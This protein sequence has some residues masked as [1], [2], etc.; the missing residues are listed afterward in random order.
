VADYLDLVAP[1][2]EQ[3]KESAKELGVDWRILAAQVIVESGGNPM[4][5]GQ[6]GEIGLC[7]FFLTTARDFLTDVTREQ[8]FEPLTNLAAQRAYLAWLKKYLHD[9]CET[10]D[11]RLALAAYNWG[12]GR[13]RLH[14]SQGR[15]FEDIPGHVRDG[16]VGKIL[17]IAG[18]L[19]PDE[20]QA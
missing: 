13:V 19:P 5:E 17:R 8:L 20:V 15:G 18:K 4:A 6:S 3:I 16:Y 9:R 10:D 1:Y 12:V 7:Q 14:L 11:F 2:A